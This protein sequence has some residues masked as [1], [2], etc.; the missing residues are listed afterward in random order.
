MCFWS[1]EDECYV[2]ESPLF[3]R[4]IGMGDTPE[5]ANEQFLDM[6]DGAWEFV[7]AGKI[8]ESKGRPLKG[9]VSIHVTVKPAVKDAIEDLARHCG[10]TQGEAVE[11]LTFY[12]GIA[13]Q[14]C[15]LVP[16]ATYLQ[17]SYSVATELGVIDSEVGIEIDKG[18]ATKFYIKPRV[19]P[20]AS[21]L[22]GVLGLSGVGAIRIPGIHKEPI[23]YFN[24][25]PCYADV[26]APV[27]REA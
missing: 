1:E 20:E 26:I 24:L 15:D 4:V 2:V 9:N 10:I 17:G 5:E 19:S 16:K 27:L 14:H 8:Y 13:T 25:E 23:G 22:V 6:L 21:V 3:D 11:Y 7:K 12:H 18:T